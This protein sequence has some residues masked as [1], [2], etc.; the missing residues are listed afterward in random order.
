M[1]SDSGQHCFITE[2]LKSFLFHYTNI[3]FLWLSFS[4]HFVNCTR[5]FLAM[6]HLWVLWWIIIK[7]EALVVQKSGSKDQMCS[8]VAECLLLLPFDSQL[9]SKGDHWCS[10]SQPN[11]NTMGNT[12]RE[13][14]WVGRK[15][16]G[17]KGR[18]SVIEGI[19]NKRG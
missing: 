15:G 14:G 2:W 10:C 16:K 19:A 18:F 12:E 13:K 17:K 6:S 5:V 4:F 8:S 1:L 9:C 7:T 11:W 3:F